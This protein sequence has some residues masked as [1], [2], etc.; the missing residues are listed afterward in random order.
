[1]PLSSADAARRWRAEN[2][3]PGRVRPDPGPSAETL[4]QRA[5]ALMGVATT[6]FDRGLLRLVA[7]DLR[8]AMRAVPKTHRHRLELHFGL[9]MELIGPH[10]LR[11]LCG[12]ADA[13][14]PQPAAIGGAADDP[15]GAEG[16]ELDPGEVIYALICG[17]A[18]IR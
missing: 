17:E 11:V 14:A 16:D 3:H 9:C 1:M 6:A 10:A 4:L 7:D 5:Q 2:L 12:P 18:H 13:P 15:P 8:A